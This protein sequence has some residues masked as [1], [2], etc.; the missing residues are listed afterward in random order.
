MKAPLNWNGNDE[1]RNWSARANA[2]PFDPGKFI[3]QFALAVIEA[4][5]GNPSSVHVQNLIGRAARRLRDLLTG[6]PHAAHD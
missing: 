5:G 3:G 1:A 2:Q 4:S 6:G